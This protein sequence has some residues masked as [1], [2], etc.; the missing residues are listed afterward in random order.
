MFGPRLPNLDGTSMQYPD[1][2][3]SYEFRGYNKIDGNKY[4]S[5]GIQYGYGIHLD[6]VIGETTP[7]IIMYK[8]KIMEIALSVKIK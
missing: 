6:Y 7:I 3:I 2:N 5:F 4:K 8:E 1:D